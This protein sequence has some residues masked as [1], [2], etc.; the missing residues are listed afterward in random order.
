M[1]EEVALTDLPERLSELE[2][3]QQV[4]VGGECYSLI[5]YVLDNLVYSQNPNQAAKIY[6]ESVT[7]SRDPSAQPM[8][9]SVLG[10]EGVEESFTV[11]RNDHQWELPEGLASIPD[12]IMGL[13]PQLRNV[14][15]VYKREDTPFSPLAFNDVFTHFD[16]VGM[17][18]VNPDNVEDLREECGEAIDPQYGTLWGA[19]IKSSDQV[20]EGSIYV[21]ALQ[22]SD[23]LAVRMIQVDELSLED[24]DGE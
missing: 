13:A 8:E 21:V 11:K 5:D 19:D 20:E 10:E 24:S 17:V 16:D 4:A 23:R 12:A 1:T 6:D 18:V 2:D 14:F 3:D 7:I 22:G 15:K 9:V